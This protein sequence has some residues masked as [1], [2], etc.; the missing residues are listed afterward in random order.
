MDAQ[1]EQEEALAKM[2]EKGMKLDP[3]KLAKVRAEN[4]S[5]TKSTQPTGLVESVM[6]KYNLS[7]EQAES[8]IE[9]FGG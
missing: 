4:S 2:V 3:K 8:E 1:Q 7:R 9:K 5:A 6:Q